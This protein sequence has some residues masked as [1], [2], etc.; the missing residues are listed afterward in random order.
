MMW[1]V[2]AGV[3]RGHPWRIA[4]G[5]GQT[6]SASVGPA[7]RSAVVRVPPRGAK[8]RLRRLDA[9]CVVHRMRLRG[10][11]SKEKPTMSIR[12]DQPNRADQPAD[13]PESASGCDSIQT[14]GSAYPCAAA[15]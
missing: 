4:R 2:N 9:P 10:G 15:P 3:G 5:H 14:Q 7:R 11:W 12:A 8:V 1:S 6:K 13:L